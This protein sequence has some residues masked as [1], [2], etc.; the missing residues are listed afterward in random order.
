LADADHAA[1]IDTASRASC[2]MRVQDIATSMSPRVSDDER[3]AFDE[4]TAA[5]SRSFQ[6]LNSI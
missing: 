6:V 1:K 2:L 5:L 4:M 3:R